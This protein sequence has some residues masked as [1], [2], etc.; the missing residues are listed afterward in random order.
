MN[1]LISKRNLKELASH[2]FSQEGNKFNDLVRIQD[3]NL[4]HE[5]NDYTVKTKEAYNTLY[6]EFAKNISENI[7]R[8]QTRCKGKLDI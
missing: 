7:S 3:D 5:S 2:Y 1:S 8:S 4:K 6:K